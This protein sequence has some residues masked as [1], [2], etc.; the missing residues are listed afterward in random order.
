MNEFEAAMGL[1]V[2][3]DMDKIVE[4]RKE[5]FKRYKNTLKD[6]MV[7]QE[8]NENSTQNY[9]Y[10]PILPETE[11]QVLKVQ[12]ALNDTEIFPRRYFYPSL[13]TLPYIKESPAMHISRE[14]SSRIL[15]LPIFPG[16]HGKDQQEIIEIIRKTV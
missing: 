9:S 8:Q 14:I 6:I 10:F 15:A 3:D 11:E 16:L 5:V 7:F 2:L 13:D 12:K 4:Q 1:C